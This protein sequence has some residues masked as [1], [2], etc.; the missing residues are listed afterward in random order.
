MEVVTPS[1]GQCIPMPGYEYLG[2]LN[3]PPLPNG[4]THCYDEV[5]S[6]GDVNPFFLEQ[7]RF[8]AGVFNGQDGTYYRAVDWHVSADAGF[9]SPIPDPPDY[10][11]VMTHSLAATAPY[12]ADWSA[13]NA[14][15]ELKDLRHIP[16]MIKEVGDAVLHNRAGPGKLIHTSANVNLFWT[17]GIQPLISDIKSCLKFAARSNSRVDDF[18][19]FSR[20]GG[21]SKNHTV[22]HEISPKQFEGTSYITGVYGAQAQ[23]TTYLT[24]ERKEWGSVNWVIPK[25]RLPPRAS[26]EYLYLASQLANGLQITPDTLWQALPW[27]WLIDWFS[28]IDDFIKL[29]YNT[30]GATS[31]RYCVMDWTR[32]QCHVESGSPG[33]GGGNG[34]FYETKRRTPMPFVYPE[35][36]LPFVSNG[37]AGILGSLAIQRAPK[38]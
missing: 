16:T 28:N 38:V 11:T 2:V 25:E 37:M 31:G 13:T 32:V 35:V 3:A 8:A 34:A 23:Y 30:I 22:Y 14:V 4:W 10:N 33:F 12:V 9:F 17:F 5:N 6:K 20:P 1:G 24:T 27:T 29:S 7:K 18:N 21:A 26:P 15:Y 19:R 36:R